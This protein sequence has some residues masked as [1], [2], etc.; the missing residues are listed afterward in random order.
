VVTRSDS[1]DLF[2]LA[3]QYAADYRASI[4]DRRVTPEAEALDA[5]RHFDH[6]LPDGPAQPLETL[7][8]LHRFGSPATVAQTGGRY[9]GFVNGGVL[10]EA[11]ASRWLIDSW[12]QNT[13]LE[14]MS[15]IGARLEH[16]CER[17]LVDLFGLPEE[18][19]AGFTNGTS[20][21][22]LC[23]LTTARHALLKKQ[24]WD[25]ARQGLQGAPRIR[26]L[27]TEHT[28]AAVLRTLQV[29]GLGLNHIE[30]VAS[31]DQGRILVEQL[32]DLD[33]RTL[34]LAQAGDVNSGAFDP[35]RELGERVR[36]ADAWM[37]VDGAFGLWAA[38]S[39]KTRHLTQGVE[40]ANSWSVDAH[41]TLN[42]PYECGI[43]LCRERD[44][45]VEA[46][47]TDASYITWG[48]GRDGMAFTL[49]MSRRARGAELWATLH[50]LG[51][52]GVEDLVDHLC[53]MAQRLSST[54]QEIGF[55]V[56]NEVVFNQVLVQTSD[57][58]DL[59]S[60]LHELQQ[61]GECWC[62]G[63]RWLGE[64]VIRVSICSH[65]TTEADIDRTAA[66]FAAAHRKVVGS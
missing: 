34:V 44:V 57:G 9:F 21:A 11:L 61:S 58:S 33:E 38:A 8:K 60:I 29:L 39:R 30:R 31:D 65:A 48:E 52:S 4:C 19:A 45:M 12:D 2:S 55:T 62:G 22:L 25:V 3:H 5:L 35:F 23:C 24:G 17:W 51:R 28:H 6:P 7:R 40:L 10:P 47:Q 54:L 27:A 42:A 49:D 43:A 18:T 63:S 64:P 36:A 14:V 37:H 59:P 46:L 20:A 53:R 1:E 13:A 15:P 26:I 16:V 41:K 56:P 66:A 32:P 50:T